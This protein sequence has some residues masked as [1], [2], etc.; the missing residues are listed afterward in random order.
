MDNN[1]KQLTP[2]DPTKAAAKAAEEA[3]KKEKEEQKQK[4]LAEQ[5]RTGAITDMEREAISRGYI[6]PDKLEEPD[7]FGRLEGEMVGDYPMFKIPMGKFIYHV[8]KKVEKF[9]P[10]NININEIEKNHEKN[11]NEKERYNFNIILFYDSIAEAYQQ[12]NCTADVQPYKYIHVFVVYKDVGR[13]R[14][15]SSGLIDEYQG[16]EGLRKIKKEFCNPTRSSAGQYNGLVFK[17]ANGPSKY[18]ICVDKLRSSGALSNYIR[19]VRS[20]K[21]TAGKLDHY[22]MLSTG[23]SAVLSESL[24]DKFKSDIENKQQEAAKMRSHFS[25]IEKEKEQEKEKQQP[26][27]GGSS[28]KRAYY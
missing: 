10:I 2:E 5:L 4:E 20:L 16:I 1:E 15:L 13:L 23:E 28:R 3:M 25:K 11:K 9:D 17:T 6:E 12:V 19:Y 24:Q 21:C 18:F 8:S 26:S 22:N 27:V 7:K 14:S